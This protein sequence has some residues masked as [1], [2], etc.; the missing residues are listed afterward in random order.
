MAAVILLP[1]LSGLMN[2]PK[3]QPKSAAAVEEV[4]DGLPP[5]P[6]LDFGDELAQMDK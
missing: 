5:E 6:S 1:T 3:R 2:R 4:N